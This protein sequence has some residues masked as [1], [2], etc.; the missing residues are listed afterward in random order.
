MQAFF[1]NLPLLLLFMASATA[2]R[3]WSEERKVGSVELLFTLPVTITQAVVGKFLAAWVFLGIAL[4]LT[5]PMVLTVAYLGDPDGGLIA[6]GYL[7]S[8]LMAGGFLAVGCFFSAVTKSQVIAVVLSVVAC[9]ALVFAGMPT[10]LN[11]LSTFLPAGLVSAVEG[12]SFLTHFE[13]LQRGVVQFRDL[14]YFVV[15]IVGWIAA[16]TVI[17]DERKAR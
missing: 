2:M 13:S 10:T 11:Y 15:L 9:A 4:A 17:L 8:F 6:V 12:T 16:C 3:L 14:A 1:T 7:A 5:F